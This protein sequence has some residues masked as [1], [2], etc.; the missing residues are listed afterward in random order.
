MKYPNNCS[1][2]ESWKMFKMIF[3][4]TFNKHVMSIK[5]NYDSS[6]PVFEVTA[7]LS[8]SLKVLFFW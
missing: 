2:V 4:S 3:K 7:Y 1:F 5:D 8:F 6:N